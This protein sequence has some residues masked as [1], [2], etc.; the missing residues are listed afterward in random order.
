MGWSK[1]NFLYSYL[2]QIKMSFLF[3]VQ[4]QRIG[5]QNRSCLEEVLVSLGGRRR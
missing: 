1:G 3:L 5:S 4:N 2:K